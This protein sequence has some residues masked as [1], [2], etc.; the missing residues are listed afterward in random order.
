MNRFILHKENWHC[1]AIPVSWCGSQYSSKAASPRQLRFLRYPRVPQ[2]L[3]IKFTSNGPNV[4]TTTSHLHTKPLSRAL[5]ATIFHISP[6]FKT[7]QTI[8]KKKN[9]TYMPFNTLNS[10]KIVHRRD[11]IVNLHTTLFGS[12]MNSCPRAQILP[13]TFTFTHF[14]GHDLE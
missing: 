13:P 10:I 2:P 9:K 6:Y 5:T 1:R 3:K 12:T 14:D 4:T 7:H 8:K 11:C